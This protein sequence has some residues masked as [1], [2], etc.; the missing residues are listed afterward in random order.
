MMLPAVTELSEL[1]RAA[2]T[3][4]IVTMLAKLAVEKSLTSKLD[5]TRMAVQVWREGKQGKS[6]QMVRAVH[7]SEGKQ[8]ASTWMVWSV[9]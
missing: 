3:G 6:A 2:D 4:A 8:A 1:Y 7:R 9:Q 5:D